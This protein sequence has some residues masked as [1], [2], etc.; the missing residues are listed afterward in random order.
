M[1]PRS[2]SSPL[3]KKACLEHSLD[4]V[5]DKQLTLFAIAAYHF[6]N[7]PEDYDE[8]V[9]RREKAKKCQN[10]L[11]ELRENCENNRNEA[12][13]RLND[14]KEAMHVMVN[15]SILEVQRQ[16]EQRCQQVKDE[17]DLLSAALEKFTSDKNSSL[18]P[19]LD[20][21]SK[22]SP[23]K[24]LFR[25]CV[26]DCSLQLAKSVL[27][28]CVLLPSDANIPQKDTGEKLLVKAKECPE[29][30]DLASEI[31]A[32]ALDLGLSGAIVNAFGAAARRSKRKLAK[33]LLLKLPF[34]A[35][36][37]QHRGV[38]ELYRVEGVVA[39]EEGNYA[40]SLKK[41][42]KGWGLLQHWSLKSP[43]MCLQLGATYVYFAK[44][45]EACGLYQRGLEHSTD[46]AISLKLSRALVEVFI[47][48]AEWKEA[49]E[50][51]ELALT[52]VQ[53]QLDAFELLQILYFLVRSH[54]ELGNKRQGLDLVDYWT[55]R[56]AADSV[57][58]E[59]ALQIIYA[60]KKYREG[61]K[62]V[63]VWQYENA[64]QAFELVHT[65][66]FFTV[67][68][69]HDLGWAYAA[70]GKQEKALIHYFKAVSIYSAHF[71]GSKEYAVC[72]ENLASLYKTINN[73][74]EAEKQ[75]LN[76]VSIYSTHF[77][78]DLNHAICL[79]SLAELYKS[80]NDHCKA[81]EQYVKA[82]LYTLDH[83]NCLGNL[84]VLYKGINN[85]GGAEEQYR[86]AASI[87][88]VYSLGI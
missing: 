4:L 47:Q 12:N 1:K 8:Y 42:E 20:A 63:A 79:E 46:P 38:V 75:Y 34:T 54:F 76:A 64:L 83:A 71:P 48:T 51:S 17:L 27:E 67:F 25:V 52:S 78:M 81:I 14:V 16:V 72:L 11:T 3:K 87:Y 28:S 26:G 40:R 15:R 56:I 69:L 23:V 41:L 60:D 32:Y 7:Q 61:D 19:A 45:R 37:E 58:S 57:E 21:M 33:K 88:S 53:G 80:M 9:L 31:Y 6:I 5:K 65:S 29:Q 73:M 55:S 24:A 62:E 39:R 2:S 35:T 44:R 43:E 59:S 68:S 13:D 49:V 74:S 22:S 10:T 82:V 84:A 30:A 66:T 86:K 36:K 50:A 77:P 18:S 85:I 70:L